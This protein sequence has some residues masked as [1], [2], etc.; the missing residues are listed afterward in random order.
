MNKFKKKSFSHT[1][2]NAVNT[3]KMY[4]LDPADMK[5]QNENLTS[6]IL[7]ELDD[8]LAVN[9]EVVRENQDVSEVI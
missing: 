2:K 1:H 4:V 5:M 9:N 8:V 3:N 7:H 6:S